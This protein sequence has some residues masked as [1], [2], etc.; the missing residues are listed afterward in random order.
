MK[1]IAKL[2]SES[3]E[4]SSRELCLK[5]KVLNVTERRLEVEEVV[6]VVQEFVEITVDSGVAKSGW[7]VWKKGF[8]S[9]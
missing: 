6:N 2:G 1:V 4:D 3:L 7:P 8:A 5:K 9:T